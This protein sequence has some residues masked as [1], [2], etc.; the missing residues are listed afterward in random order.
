MKVSENLT[1]M[2]DGHAGSYGE[3]LSNHFAKSSRAETN[4]CSEPGAF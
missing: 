3:R 4:A 2:I 1:D